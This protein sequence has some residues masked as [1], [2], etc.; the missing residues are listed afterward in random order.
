[1]LP[2][3]FLILLATLYRVLPPLLGLQVSWMENVSPLAAIVLCGAAFFP[4]KM[5][6]LVP[7]LILLV[8]DVVLNHF[9]YH[10]PLFTWEILPRYV[11]LAFTGYLAFGHREVLQ[12]KAT[13]MLG[14]SVLASLFFYIMTNTTSW[15]GD[16]A[17]SRTFSGWLQALTVGL[18]GFP[19]TYTFFRNSLIG[20]LLFTGLFVACMAITSRKVIAPAV[21]SAPA[22]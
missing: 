22:Y 2:G 3:L 19:P 7:L 1:M 16:P 18:P 17:Y 20:D 15:A 9:A 6:L 4:K 8:S 14:A 21:E 12:R 11:V 10:A 5:A 13:A